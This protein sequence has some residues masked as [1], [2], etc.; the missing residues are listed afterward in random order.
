[1]LASN[2]CYDIVDARGSRLGAHCGYRS[3]EEAEAAIGDEA[4]YED[5]VYIV[6]VTTT[7]VKVFTNTLTTTS[8]DLP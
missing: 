5:E 1:M 3:L 6:R 4:R 7:P 2:E 8:Q